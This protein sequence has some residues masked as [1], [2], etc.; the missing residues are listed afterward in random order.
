MAR[1]TRPQQGHAGRHQRDPRRGDDARA[2]ERD[3]DS[4]VDIGAME[5]PR[6]A[7]QRIFRGEHGFGA[8]LDA[9]SD[10]PEVRQR[11][12]VPRRHDR[13]RAT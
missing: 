4:L 11:R 10:A 6:A 12:I 1:R 9:L 5:P 13:S 8:W 7:L 3:M 2:V